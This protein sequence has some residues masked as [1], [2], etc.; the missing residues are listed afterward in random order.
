ME[1]RIF[2]LLVSSFELGRELVTRNS[3]LKTLFS[4]RLGVSPFET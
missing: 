1:P 4:V 3:K 2:Q